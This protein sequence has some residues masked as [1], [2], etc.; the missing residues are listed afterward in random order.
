MRAVNQWH[1]LARSI[2]TRTHTSKHRHA[3]THTH[4]H[5]S[6]H[7]AFTYIPMHASSHT[8]SDKMPH[9]HDDSQA[10]EQERHIPH[11]NVWMP[12]VSESVPSE[13]EIMKLLRSKELIQA[14]VADQTK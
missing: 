14:H 4:T 9:S 10:D 2:R 5:A 7:I 13:I 8:L 12:S 1:V 3:H 6:E 11:G